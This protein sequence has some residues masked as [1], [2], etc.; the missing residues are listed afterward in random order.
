M[1][2][3]TL[4]I[5]DINRINDYNVQLRNQSKFCIVAKRFVSIHFC[6]LFICLL[7]YTLTLL[8]IFEII[9]EKFNKYAIII[10]NE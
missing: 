9:F 3:K 7:L 10:I 1:F 5:E 2:E 4:L 6:C 8:Y